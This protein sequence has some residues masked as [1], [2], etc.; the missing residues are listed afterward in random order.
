MFRSMNSSNQPLTSKKRYEAMNGSASNISKKVKLT[1]EQSYGDKLLDPMPK[2]VVKKSIELDF[3][4]KFKKD[5]HEMTRN[6]LEELIL[7]KVV[8]AILYKSELSELRHKTDTQESQILNLKKITTEL[9]KQYNDLDTIYKK[10]VAHSKE[11]SS[12]CSIAP[13]K[14]QRSVG[15]QVSRAKL[16]KTDNTETTQIQSQMKKV[17][18]TV[19]IPSDQ[20]QDKPRITQSKQPLQQ[21]LDT[22]QQAVSTEPN[23][24]RTIVTPSNQLQDKPKITQPKQHLSISN[25]CSIPKTNLETTQITSQMKKVVGTVVTLT[26][27]LQHALA[28]QQAVS[29][30]SKM[31]SDQQKGI[32]STVKMIK[33]RSKPTNEKN[34]YSLAPQ[35]KAS[36]IN[37]NTA[38]QHPAPLPIFIN[39]SNP[40]WKSIPPRPILLVN[41]ANDGIVLSWYLDVAKTADY[42]DILKY[43]IY[44]YQK[45]TSSPPATDNWLYICDVKS[46][47]LPMS[48][49]LKKFDNSKIVYFAICAVDEHSRCGSFSLPRPWI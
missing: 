20:Q 1:E 29:S 9:A 33:A 12:G 6:D 43:Q 38:I 21:P 39:K 23:M 7:Q 44:G 22:Q 37:C 46:K 25:P 2:K 40:A 11:K 3:L 36:S 35:P 47:L 34:S 16:V 45:T 4:K 41:I 10:F 5:F 14:I 24:V 31:S 32:D 30:E 13:F 17:V 49:K 15:I 42:A 27:T 18:K 26:D 19:I 28:T 48:V 8:E